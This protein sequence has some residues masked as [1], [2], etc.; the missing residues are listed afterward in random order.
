VNSNRLRFAATFLLLAVPALNGCAGSGSSVRTVTPQATLQSPKSV[1]PGSVPAPSMSKAVAPASLMNGRRPKSNKQPLGFTQIDGAATVVAASPDG[2]IWALSTNGPT[3]GPDK[4][5]FHY[6]GGTWT[7]VPGAAIRIAV[8]PDNTAYV[9]NS[10]GG[11]YQ[12]DGSPWKAIV[13]GAQDITV[14]V[15]GSLYVISNVPGEEYGN[16]IYHYSG[17]VWTRMPSAAQRVIASW[18]PGTYAGFISPGG[19]Y[20]IQNG[21]AYYYDPVWAQYNYIPFNDNS[22]YATN[23]TDIA[24]TTTAAA[25]ALAAAADSNGGHHI[26][27]E[28]WGAAYRTE[29]GSGVSISS[30]GPTIDVAGPTGGIYTSAITPTAPDVTFDR[31][32]LYVGKADQYSCTTSDYCLPPQQLTM[33]ADQANGNPGPFRVSTWCKD[34]NCNVLNCFITCSG[35]VIEAQGNGAGGPKSIDIFPHRVGRAVL[36][37]QGTNG[38]AG[39]LP[40]WVTTVSTGITFNALAGAQ[41]YTV[42]DGGD[43]GS[44]TAVSAAAY[45]PAG[46]TVTILNMRANGTILNNNGS[47]KLTKYIEV[48][49]SNGS[50]NIVD[51]VLPVNVV[52]GQDN[53]VAI[54]IP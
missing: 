17:G 40:A 41:T 16:G 2:T 5:I 28:A 31:P 15:D 18:D 44:E 34:G 12:Y 22:G 19:Y 4:Y 42:T 50:T 29:G 1:S 3:S 20:I 6:V 48:T 10:A 47:P 30:N 54:T 38:G 49:V 53:P 25:Y 11:I 9:V 7:N 43:W 33:Y 14:A 27:L 13:G 26:L 39:S 23:V 32:V 52:I 45:P 37:A 35:K 8:G 51:K 21:A 36:I 24:P 46:K